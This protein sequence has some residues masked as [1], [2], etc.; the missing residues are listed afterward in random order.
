MRGPADFA[1]RPIQ[2][3]DN[4]RFGS[5]AHKQIYWWP[6]VRERDIMEFDSHLKSPSS[7]ESV[8]AFRRD[9]RTAQL[10]AGYGR[11]ST[12]FSQLDVINA[13]AFKPGFACVSRF[14]VCL[15]HGSKCQS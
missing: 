11:S 4:P 15:L 1:Q 13:S 12:S 7:R 8:L 9:S 5:R 3:I 6:V 10:V 14:C 2:P